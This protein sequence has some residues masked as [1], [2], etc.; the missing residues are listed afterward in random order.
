MVLSKRFWGTTWRSFLRTIQDNK[1]IQSQDRILALVSGGPDS[2]TMAYW[3]G[4]LQKHIPF[5]WAI[6]HFDHGL[7]RGSRSDALFVKRLAN[8]LGVKFYFKRIPVKSF[9]RKKRKSLED[10]GR[11]LRYCWALKLARHYRFNKVATAHTLNDQAESVLLNILRGGSWDGLRG[12]R[13]KRPLQRGSRAILIRPLI[14]VPKKEILAFLQTAKISFRQDPTN[15]DPRFLR[16]RL[17]LEILPR[18]CSLQPKALE[19]IAQV[20][21]SVAK[22]ASKS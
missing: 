17:R 4:L 13:C 2:T 7:R 20:A 21:Q 1:L 18:L 3:F 14:E 10:A 22:R 9:A 19:H 8:K 5:D 12:A 11:T 16:N 6:L 15:S